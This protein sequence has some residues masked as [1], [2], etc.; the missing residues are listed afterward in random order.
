MITAVDGVDLV[1]EDGEFLVLVG[2]SG[3]GK[4]TTLRMLSGLETVDSGTIRIDDRDITGKKPRERNIAMVFQNYA[5]YPHKTV[6]GNL[7]YPLE[8]RTDLSD[9]DI[10]DRVREITD[11]L[12]ISE[13]ENKNPAQL[14]G[15]QKQR[16]SLG[17]ALVREPDIFLMD[18]PLSNLD[19]KL[20]MDMRTEIQRIQDELGITTIYVTHDQEEAMSMSDRLAVMNE[21]QIQ[22]VSSPDEVYD[23]PANTFVAQ[24]IGSP[25]MNFFEITVDN[26]TISGDDIDQGIPVS[27]PLSSGEYLLGVRPEDIALS[28]PPADEHAVSLSAH[29][30]VIEPIGNESIVYAT[31]GDREISIKADRSETPPV[32]ERVDLYVPQSSM[33]L[34]DPDSGDSLGFGSV[35]ATE[36]A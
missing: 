23:H 31:I 3:C 22:Q 30:D 16:V 7:R 17:R 29:I 6:D 33:H 10:Q 9:A 15:G 2:P 26:S 4:S 12:D 21:G 8:K 28:E 32:D 24:F 11:L 13:L 18:E 19:A 1:V 36:L 20:R 27:F 35:A 5:L 34:F 25:S 14:S